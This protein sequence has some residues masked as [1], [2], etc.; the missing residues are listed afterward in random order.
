MPGETGRFAPQDMPR[1]QAA[2]EAQVPEG[3]TDMCT[4][5]AAQASSSMKMLLSLYLVV[6]MLSKVLW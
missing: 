2:K 3:K 6:V 4:L 5:Q 1:E